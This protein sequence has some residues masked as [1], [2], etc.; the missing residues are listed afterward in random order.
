M[1]V[2]FVIVTAAMLRLAWRNLTLP[3]RLVFRNIAKPFKALGNLLTL[4]AR[5]RRTRAETAILANPRGS[6]SVAQ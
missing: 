4:P 3:F 1:E 2:L 5:V 6:L